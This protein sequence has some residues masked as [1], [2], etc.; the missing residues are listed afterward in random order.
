MVW[1]VWIVHLAKRV[2]FVLGGGAERVEG[3]CFLVQP[4]RALRLLDSK[5]LHLWESETER[6]AAFT[7]RQKRKP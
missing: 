6:T 4:F 5:P 1:C 3:L 7:K 2:E